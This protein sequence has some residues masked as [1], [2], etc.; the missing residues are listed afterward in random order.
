MEYVKSRPLVV[1]EFGILDFFLIHFTEFAE[2]SDRNIC[3][4]SKRA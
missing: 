3:Q 1:S 4:Y 2:F